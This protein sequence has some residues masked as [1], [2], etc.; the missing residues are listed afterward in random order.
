MKQGGRVE[1]GDAALR[2]QLIEDAPEREPREDCLLGDDQRASRIEVRDRLGRA[3][4][5]RDREIVVGDTSGDEADAG[6]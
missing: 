1:P 4:V 2:H 5:R 6:Q 3:L